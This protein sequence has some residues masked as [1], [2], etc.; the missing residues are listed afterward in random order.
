MD[1]QTKSAPQY[2]PTEESKP[3]D[4]IQLASY[5]PSENSASVD[6]SINYDAL[7][8]SVRSQSSL[9]AELIELASQVKL[10]KEQLSE[11]VAKAQEANYQIGF[12]QAQ[13]LIQQEQIKELRE[14]SGLSLPAK[15]GFG[16]WF[17]NAFL[18][19]PDKHT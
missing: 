6:L 17:R 10:L 2:L 7:S 19:K 18:S 4:K 12:L 1:E 16:N 8:V 9:S 15:G 14:K 5:Q 11:S 3:T 13:V